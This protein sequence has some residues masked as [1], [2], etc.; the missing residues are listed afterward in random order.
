MSFLSVV[1]YDWCDR[2]QTY[3]ERGIQGG[4]AHQEENRDL[5]VH[6]SEMDIRRSCR[7]FYWTCSVGDQ[8]GCGE[9][10]WCQVPAH[11]QIHGV[12]PVN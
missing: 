5:A 11:R 3:R 12:R 9:H 2:V 4:L 6:H 8:F 10:R 7:H 1:T